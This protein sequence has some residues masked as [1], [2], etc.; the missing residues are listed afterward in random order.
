M[1]ASPSI[2]CIDT[3][4]VIDWHERFYPPE[5]FPSLVPLVDDLIEANRLLMSEE[6]FLELQA[7]TAAAG[8][9]CDARKDKLVLPTDASVATAVRDVL[10]E[11]PRLV[12]ALKNRNRADPF[13]IAVARLKGAVVVTGEVGGTADRPKIPYV[14]GQL[15]IRCLGFVDLIKAEGWRL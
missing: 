7:K 15:G 14:C 13:V 1:N 9:W 6:V 11:H 2:Y 8:T 3:S 12:G 5:S 10:R 4:S